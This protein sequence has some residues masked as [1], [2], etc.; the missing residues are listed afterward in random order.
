LPSP[1]LAVAGDV[2][3]ELAA[4]A[5][6]SGLVERW[7][8]S[9]ARNADESLAYA[10]AQQEVQALRSEAGSLADQAWFDGAVAL[11]QGVAGGKS[12]AIGAILAGVK[13]AG[14]GLHSADQKNDEATAKGFEAAATATRSAADGARDA[15]AG[16]DQYVQSALEL[17]RQYVTTEGQIGS[18]ASSGR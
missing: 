6:Q 12:S 16:A 3:A 9:D 10:Q 14:D 2:G 11:S 4:L 13:G 8:A 18:A 15:A 17:F 1:R 7:E 5:V